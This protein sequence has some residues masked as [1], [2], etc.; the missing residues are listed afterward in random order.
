MENYDNLLLMKKNIETGF[1]TEEIGS[2]KINNHIEYIEKIYLADEVDNSYIYLTLTS[3]EVEEDWKY[4]GI[5]DLYNLDIYN[6]KISEIEELADTYT[7]AWT[8]KIQYTDNYVFIENLLNDILALHVSELER[9][10]PLINEE[11]YTE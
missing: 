8:L 7:P 11:D 6:E 2:Y 10:I 4:Y 1:L 5:L 9:I 3:L